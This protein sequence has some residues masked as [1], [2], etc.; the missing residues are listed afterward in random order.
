[1]A[2][3]SYITIEFP[4]DRMTDDIEQL[5]DDAA[6]FCDQLDGEVLVTVEEAR[7]GF[8]AP[9]AGSTGMED[10]AGD[11]WTSDLVKELTVEGV[12]FWG[13]DAGGHEWPEQEYAWSPDHGWKDRQLDGVGNPVMAAHEF[14]RLME[15]G[16]PASR[17]VEVLAEHFGDDPRGWL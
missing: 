8:P 16:L 12:P 10:Y 14:A 3:Y 4:L 2:D 13:Y 17:I 7:Y 1:M 15:S 11:P 9:Y 5:V 6:T